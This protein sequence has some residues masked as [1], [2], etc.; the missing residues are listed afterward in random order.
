MQEEMQA[1]PKDLE[2]RV[3]DLELEMERLKEHDLNQTKARILELKQKED[4]CNLRMLL[5]SH[6]L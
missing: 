2:S 3:A 1:Q 6:K 5:S 4:E